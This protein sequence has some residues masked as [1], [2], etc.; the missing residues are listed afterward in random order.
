MWRAV[1]CFHSCSFRLWSH[2][3]TFDDLNL[4][5]SHVI[6]LQH[7]TEQNEKLPWYI[8]DTMLDMTDPSWGYRCQLI[9]PPPPPYVCV[10]QADSQSRANLA[11]LQLCSTNWIREVSM[12]HSWMNR[13]KCGNLKLWIFLMLPTVLPKHKLL[14]GLMKYISLPQNDFDC[15][16]TQN[17]L[18]NY[19]YSWV[20][21]RDNCYINGQGTQ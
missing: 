4:K 17:E 21:L 8:N 14:C 11:E 5:H 7:F 16:K 9:L 18:S 3:M 20:V 1:L 12:P 15:S 19:S 10:Y 13:I 2:W 6:F